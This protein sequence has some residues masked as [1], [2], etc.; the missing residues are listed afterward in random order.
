MKRLLLIFAILAMLLTA[1][2]QSNPTEA[3]PE[4]DCDY[5]AEEYQAEPEPEPPAEEPDPAPPDEP[6]AQDDEMWHRFGGM[7]F[8]DMRKSIMEYGADV[9]ED[10]T[11]VSIV[12]DSPNDIV[13][14]T[15]P[16]V[17]ARGYSDSMQ[18]F[19]Y[20]LF[21]WQ[22]WRS[23]WRVDGYSIWGRWDIQPQVTRGIREG[24]RY[25]STDTVDVRFYSSDADWGGG[26]SSPAIYMSIPGENFAEEFIV[27]FRRYVGVY[28]LDMWFIGDNR[29][30]VN[31]DNIVMDAQGSS[32]G[33]AVLVALYRTLFNLPDVE[34]V[35]VLVGGQSERASDHMGFAHI[36]RRDDPEIQRWLKL[37]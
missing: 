17:L 10:A 22:N 2:C 8:G 30:Y 6:L 28:M 5:F 11:G 37:P 21:T 15:D 1:A 34:E 14:V 29:L 27:L 36:Y 20:V 3:V 23:G 35:V 31:L 16:L 12:F 13:S 32:A 26:E 18:S 19:I 33:I 7:T 9:F 4:P 24:R 25:V